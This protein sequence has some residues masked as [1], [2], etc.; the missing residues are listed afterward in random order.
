MGLPIPGDKNMHP[1]GFITEDVRL[2]IF[3][4]K[5]KSEMKASTEGLR[6][7]RTGGCPF[8]LFA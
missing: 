5:G 3:V 2:N 6:N 7:E 8:L 4:G 1:E